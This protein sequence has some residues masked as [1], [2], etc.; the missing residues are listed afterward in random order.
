MVIWMVNPF[1]DSDPKVII[2][3]IIKNWKYDSDLLEALGLI[4][5]V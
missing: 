4:A 2:Q 5:S 3:K 1:I